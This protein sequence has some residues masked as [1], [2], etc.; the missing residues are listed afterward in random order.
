MSYYEMTRVVTGENKAYK[1]IWAPWILTRISFFIWQYLWMIL[2]VDRH[3]IKISITLV[4]KCSFYT[5]PKTESINLLFLHSKLA[6]PIWTL[7]N[8]IFN[9]R[10]PRCFN[11]YNTLKIC[12]R[13]RWKGSAE[14]FCFTLTLILI[15]WEIWK[16]DKGGILR[17]FIIL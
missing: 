5:F 11:T 14:S 15:L 2:P 16:K 4:S 12:F 6:M 17:R 8:G 7:F 13:D 10:W 1:N 3:L 9:L